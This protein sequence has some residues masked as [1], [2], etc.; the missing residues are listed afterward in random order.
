M[1]GNK[2]QNLVTTPLTD[3]DLS[4]YVKGYNKKSY[5]YDLYGVANHS[6]GS[7]GG[8]YT[9]YVKNANGKWYEFNDTNINEIKKERIVSTKSYC[10]FFRKKK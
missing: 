5:V 2:K 7:L 9:A 6:G 8:H 1:T 10:F 3:V 4:K